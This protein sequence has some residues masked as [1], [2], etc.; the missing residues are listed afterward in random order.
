MISGGG[1]VQ[2]QERKPQTFATDG[3]RADWQP[4]AFAIG[5]GIAVALI[6]SLASI[7]LPTPV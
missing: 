1:L 3:T 6:L 7:W 4:Y 2:Y 5:A